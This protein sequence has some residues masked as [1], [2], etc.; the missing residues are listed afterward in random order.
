MIAE[1]LS[2]VFSRRNSIMAC[3]DEER[4]TSLDGK[5]LLHAGGW[6]LGGIACIFLMLFVPAIQLPASWEGAVMLFVAT[7]CGAFV[8]FMFVRWLNHLD[9]VRG[10]VPPP[11]QEAPLDPK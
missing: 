3:M 7:S 10:K 8:I 6:L 5:D 2:G 11:S 4:R 1:Y 9:E